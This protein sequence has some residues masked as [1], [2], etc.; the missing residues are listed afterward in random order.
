M[1]SDTDCHYL[2]CPQHVFGNLYWVCLYGQH[3]DLRVDF[4]A[5]IREGRQGKI[6][7][8]PLLWL[9]QVG[10]T[11]RAD[12]LMMTERAPKALISIC[13]IAC[14]PSHALVYLARLYVLM[15][16][17]VVCVCE[18]GNN[19]NMSPCLSYQNDSALTASTLLR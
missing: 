15:Q 19:G 13:M 10:S 5:A 18:A 17:G 1:L 9:V 12:S 7:A 14:T 8:T 6:T 4:L 3:D 2:S 11:P 16:W